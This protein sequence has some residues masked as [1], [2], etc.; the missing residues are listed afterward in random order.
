M[1]QSLHR[2]FDH[3]DLRVQNL[4]LARPFYAALLPAPGFSKDVSEGTWFQSETEQSGGAGE[5]FG[6]IE[7]PSHVSNETRVA[8]WAESTAKVDQL[9]GGRK[10]EGPGYDEGLAT[11]PSFLKTR[12]VTVLKSAIAR[13][14]AQHECLA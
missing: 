5:F 2:R 6:L 7:F 12:A 3:I 9:A 13:R 10:I 4:A 8:F 11:T 1:L 14:R